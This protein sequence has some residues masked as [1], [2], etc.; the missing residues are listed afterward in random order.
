MVLISDEGVEGGWLKGNREG[1][2]LLRE[3]ID[4]ALAS[5]TATISEDGI[6]L[7]GIHCR[8]ISDESAPETLASKMAGWGCLVLIVVCFAIFIFG[9]LELVGTLF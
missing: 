5:G 1:L 6:E 7:A 9:L 3:A 8:E 4:V 2:V